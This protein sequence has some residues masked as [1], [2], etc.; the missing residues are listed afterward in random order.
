MS[1]FIRPPAQLVEQHAVQEHIYPAPQLM[2]VDRSLASNDHNGHVVDLSISICV[3]HTLEC[4]CIP[5]MI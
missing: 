3:S 2:L 5:L 4:V 1:Q